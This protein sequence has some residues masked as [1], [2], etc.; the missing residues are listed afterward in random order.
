MYMPTRTPVC[1]SLSAESPLATYSSLSVSLCQHTSAHYPLYYYN[2][3]DNRVSRSITLASPAT[4][5]YKQCC[6]RHDTCIMI[7]HICGVLAYYWTA[8]QID[9]L[10]PI[11][12]FSIVANSQRQFI[13]AVIV[14][15]RTHSDTNQFWGDNN[16]AF[17]RSWPEP[18]YRAQAGGS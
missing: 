17:I 3:A 6:T 8:E 1:D 12:S 15:S 2:N 9:S 10:L 16:I 5:F 13:A 4:D 14:N 18:F 11:A 7:L